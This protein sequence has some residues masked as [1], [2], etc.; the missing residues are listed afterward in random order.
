ELSRQLVQAQ[1]LAGMSEKGEIYKRLI[2]ASVGV[3]VQEV[4]ELV[5][6]VLRE[7]E[8]EKGDVELGLGFGK[9]LVGGTGVVV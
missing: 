9:G 1:A 4:A 2:A 3:S 8:V 7:L 6:D 5:P